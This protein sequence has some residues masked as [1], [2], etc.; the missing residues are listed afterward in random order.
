MLKSL[1][2]DNYAL[3]EHS[4]I[5]F[6]SGFTVITGETGAGKSIM[7]G[8]LA[9]LL[10]QRAE[11]SVLKNPDKKCVVEAAFEI[12]DY[13]LRPFFEEN[14]LDYDE[15]CV[16]RRE[17]APSGKSRGFINDTPVTVT[18]LKELGDHLIDIHSQH[19][20]LLL[21]KADFQL[22]VVDTIAANQQQ[23]TDYGANY[24]QYK[25]DRAALS[26]LREEAARSASD[27]EFVEFQYKQLADAN[28]VPD[29]LQNLEDE[30]LKLGNTESIKTGLS[31]AYWLLEGED[32]NINVG[33]KDAIAA[34]T[35]VTPSFPKIQPYIDRLTSALIDL[36]D[37]AHDVDA[38]QNDI[39]ADPDRLQQVN[40]RL[41]LLYTLLHKHN[42]EG[43]EQLISL[44]EEFAARLSRMSNYDAD[45]ASLEEKTA[46]GK[47][48]L[49]KLA[50]A[51]SARRQ[52]QAPDIEKQIISLLRSL[53]MPNAQLQISF[54]PL[55]TLT[56]TGQDEVTFLFSANK[57]RTLQPIA[58][59]AS[60][61]EMARVM[62][63][64]KSVLAQSLNMPTIIFDE[65]DTGVSGDIAAKMGTI[66]QQM[67]Q[68]IQVISITH[69]PQIAAKGQ[70]HFTVYKEDTETSTLSHIRQLT[71]EERINELAKMLSGDKLT[72]AAI[73]NA[74]NLLEDQ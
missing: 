25:S 12:A 4:D 68:H 35:E 59:I 70:F 62:L 5:K 41:D 46:A 8:A 55:E 50:S 29:E 61:G 74:K 40:E 19:Q 23:L 43:V 71:E 30:Q 54:K 17:I 57:E 14:G 51:L 53:G 67:G 33:L 1:I 26:H 66:M 24:A 6:E 22:G 65:I 13:S 45:I 3:I 27:R 20:N 63:S 49:E 60:G 44:R 31:R 56:E 28:L 39:E 47:K 37:I 21:S 16:V 34:L 64:L 10:G 42:V 72:E 11:A 38:L 58:T 73:Q 69:L 18:L 2:I 52:K 7:L 36:K 15:E 32:T 9:L 48:K